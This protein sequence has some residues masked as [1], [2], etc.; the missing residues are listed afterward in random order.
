[1]SLEIRDLDA[2]DLRSRAEVQRLV[3]E[4]NA[5][6]ERLFG[7]IATAKNVDR[8][9]LPRIR[10][11]YAKTLRANARSGDWIQAADGSWKQHK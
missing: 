3:K 11:T 8:S 2:V 9:Q 1:M 6:R 10:E 7:E 5:D 4:E